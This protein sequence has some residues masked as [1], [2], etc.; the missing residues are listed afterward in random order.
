MRLAARGVRD[1]DDG[2][3]TI[4]DSVIKKQLQKQANKVKME[5]LAMAGSLTALALILPGRSR[6]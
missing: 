3:E 2:E 1:L 5:S 6:K 4:E